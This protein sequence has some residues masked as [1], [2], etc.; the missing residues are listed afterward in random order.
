M[1]D[2]FKDTL[3]N[4]DRSELVN[5]LLMYSDITSD[6]KEYISK[7]RFRNGHKKKLDSVI[8]EMKKVIKEK[9]ILKGIYIETIDVNSI[10]MSDIR[11]N[12]RR[13][14]WGRYRKK[15]TSISTR[16]LSE[17]LTQG[18]LEKLIQG[19]KLQCLIISQDGGVKESEISEIAYESDSPDLDYE[20]I[21]ESE[22]SDIKYKEDDD[23]ESVEPNV[24]TLSTTSVGQSCVSAILT[25]LRVLQNKHNWKN[26]SVDSFI[27]NYLST[28]KK[29]A[30]LFKYEMD[31]INEEVMRTFNKV[32]FKHQ[33]SKQI[34]VKKIYMQLRQM[35]EML[36]YTHHGLIRH[37]P[38]IKRCRFQCDMCG[39]YF[40]GSTDYINH[41]KE[42]HPAL[43]CTNCEKVFT[44]PLSLKKHKYH[45]QD[46]VKLCKHCGRSFPFDCQLN[47]H[48]KMHL[49]KKL[50]WCSY[51]NC[52]RSFMHKYDLR[53]HERTHTKTVLSCKD[54]DYKTKDV[55]NL[56]QQ[57]RIHT[58][59]KPYSCTKCDKCFTFFVQKKRHSC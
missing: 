39:N 51:V 45:H 3:K 55:R 28:K 6:D 14:I 1:L 58:G 59:I 46:N 20:P 25:Q 16:H 36:Q 8:I 18:E 15:C 21:E 27:R 52:D 17:G 44:N 10:R 57:K 5:E 26:E 47:D 56:K 41:Y 30:K 42:T 54:C 43:L 34:R 53:K 32:L 49:P 9:K 37:G 4:K 40:T 7:M 2:I 38:T 22:I 50:H 29:I 19:S 12:Q 33:D 11:T 31:I 35:P 24:S 48:L 23:Y 13:Y